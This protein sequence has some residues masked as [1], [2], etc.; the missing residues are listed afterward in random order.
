MWAAGRTWLST[1]AMAENRRVAVKGGG[2]LGG[3]RVS[4]HGLRLPLVLGAALAGSVV[5][6]LESAG[7]SGL[8]AIWGSEDEPRPLSHCVAPS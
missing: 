6:S 7:F 2:H 3:E 4:G 5:L 8:P 1:F